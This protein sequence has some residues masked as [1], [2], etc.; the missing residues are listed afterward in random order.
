MPHKANS[1]GIQGVLDPYAQTTINP[2]TGE[3]DGGNYSLNANVNVRAGDASFVRGP[4]AQHGTTGY[5]AT[6][7]TFSET[8]EGYGRTILDRPQNFRLHIQSNSAPIPYGHL[9]GRGQVHSDA[10]GINSAS[11]GLSGEMLDATAG[12]NRNAT[13][14]I[15]ER[16]ID[17]YEKSMITARTTFQVDQAARD[18]KIG[19]FSDLGLE[20]M[21]RA[22]MLM[23]Y[24][25]ITANPESKAFF[26]KHFPTLDPNQAGGGIDR[27]M[28]QW[29]NDPLTGQRRDGGY[30]M[31]QDIS[32]N[33]Q[34]LLGQSTLGNEIATHLSNSANDYWASHDAGDL[35]TAIDGRRG[36]FFEGN[37]QDE[38]GSNYTSQLGSSKE[39]GDLNNYQPG[40]NPAQ[41]AHNQRR[42]NIINSRRSRF[43]AFVNEQS[44]DRLRRTGMGTST[45]LTQ[46][47][48]PKNAT[49]GTTLL[50]SDNA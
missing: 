44:R 38:G 26:D 34:H 47:R 9:G 10:L 6:T 29:Q 2:Y 45:S 19:L 24:E 50:R 37:W 42:T 8:Y 46:T 7:S 13:T 31:L 15:V 18:S 25:F 12:L 14:G 49:T 22:N 21:A 39:Q 27:Q 17:N 36:G 11:P 1:W 16:P 28:L 3:E 5:G 4:G 48:A 20:E 30:V 41:N 43:S 32:V 23:P 40:Q 33:Q 35:Y